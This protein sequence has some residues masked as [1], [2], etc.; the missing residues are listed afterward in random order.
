MGSATVPVCIHVVANLAY[1][2]GALLRLEITA[3]GMKIVL[4]NNSHSAL[5]R[6]TIMQLRLARNTANCFQIGM[7]AAQ[8]HPPCHNS[9]INGLMPRENVCS[10]N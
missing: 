4:P 8:A 6:W 5:E 10:N 1:Q 9:V 2:A 7:A 3:L